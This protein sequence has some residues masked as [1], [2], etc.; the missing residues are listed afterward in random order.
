MTLGDQPEP[1]PKFP[2]ITIS[3][4]THQLIR[5]LENIAV[6]LGNVRRDNPAWR[7]ETGDWFSKL[8]MVRKQLYSRLEEIERR[9]NIERNIQVRFD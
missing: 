1:T 2:V 3:E 8:S 6:A 5:S 4:P 9:A 7:E